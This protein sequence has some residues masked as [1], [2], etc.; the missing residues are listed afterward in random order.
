MM[1]QLHH[2]LQTEKHQALLDNVAEIE[3][4]KDDSQRMF[5]AVRTIYSTTGNKPLF[6]ETGDGFTADPGQQVQVI[7]EFFEDMFSKSDMNQIPDIPPAE[8][9]KRFTKE[10]IQKAVN[11]LKNNKSAGIDNLKAEQLKYGPDNICEEIAEMFNDIAKTGKHPKEMKIGQLVPLQKPGKKRGPVSNLRPIILLSVLRKIMAI[12]LIQRI[13]QKISDAIPVTQAAY[14]P[15]R[16]T[17]EQVFAI[18]L[19][20]EKAVTSTDYSAHVLLMDMSKAFYTIHRDKVIEHLRRILKPDELHLVKILI[21]DV[22][23]SVKVGDKVGTPQGDCLS[24]TLFTLYLAKALKEGDP[25]ST[26]AVINDHAYCKPFNPTLNQIPEN[27]LRDHTYSKAFTTKPGFMTELQYADDISWLAGNYEAGIEHENRTVPGKLAARNLTIN[28]AKTEEYIINRDTRD[29]P[30]K[31]CK[32][33]GSLLDTA[34]D[35]GKRKESAFI[36]YHRLRPILSDRKLHIRL[37]V[38]IFTALISSIFL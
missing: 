24:P 20:A 21:Q 34:A 16:S 1:N 5:K 31:N 18:K 27:I 9:T 12:C 2:Q 3:K 10:E 23:L 13:G 11:K 15:G 28:P 14:R 26:D 8:M 25:H 35:I 19:L 22:Q 4:A 29:G 36:A 37:K 38:R 17:T 30:W 32:Y 33:L 7:T 6:I